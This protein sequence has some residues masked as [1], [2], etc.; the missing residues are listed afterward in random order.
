MVEKTN[1][2]MAL[3]FENLISMILQIVETPYHHW[4]SMHDQVIRHGVI[5]R[6][7]TLAARQLT[8]KRS[9][10]LT[11][12]PTVFLA[13]FTLR[14]A[15]TVYGYLLDIDWIRSRRIRLWL[16]D[17]LFPAEARFNIEV[18]GLFMSVYAL[19]RKLLELPRTLADYRF[20]SLILI[21]TNPRRLHFTN[22]KRL[23]VVYQKTVTIIRVGSSLILLMSFCVHGSGWPAFKTYPVLTFV[24]VLIFHY[25]ALLL[26]TGFYYQA[27]FHT[28]LFY[29]R[30]VAAQ[31]L[32][33]INNLARGVARRIPRCQ[34]VGL[35]A[36]D[37][38]PQYFLQRYYRFAAGYVRFTR[39]MKE[40]QNFNWKIYLSCIFVFVQL[41]ATYLVYLVVV[42]NLPFYYK[43][44]Y[45]LFGT[46]LM[47]NIVPVM[48]Y[49]NHIHRLNRSIGERLF[50]VNVGLQRLAWYPAGDYI[51]VSF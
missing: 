3:F 1:L 20:L 4:R 14:T 45:I 38:V 15:T 5:D 10:L 46:M 7:D 43:I 49:C 40:Y 8:H 48:H 50:Q 18:L 22:V 19:A 37:N 12:V 16:G 25:W 47:I 30:L 21:D 9:T 29:Y 17:E 41:I 44:I 33:Q 42:E 24:Q 51:K 31:Y 11:T 26:T 36:G 2:R 35:A 34:Q 32:S 39:E 28:I 6:G 23:S 13:L 27:M